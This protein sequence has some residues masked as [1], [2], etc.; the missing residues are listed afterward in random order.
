MP[1]VSI[2]RTGVFEGGRIDDEQSNGLPA[3]AQDLEG[4]ERTRLNRICFAGR[5]RVGRCRGGDAR[6]F[7]QH[8]QDIFKGCH[9]V[10]GGRK[11][12]QLEV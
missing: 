3:E 11:P 4:P 9:F 5:I 12:R 1:L 10:V 2:F 7:D 6:H 8:Q